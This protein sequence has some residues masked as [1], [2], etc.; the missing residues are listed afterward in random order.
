MLL[1]PDFSS[2]QGHICCANIRRCLSP[3]VWVSTHTT[4]GVCSGLARAYAR[5]ISPLADCPSTGTCWIPGS[6]RS[7]SISAVVDF[8]LA[9]RTGDDM[10][11]CCQSQPHPQRLDGRLKDPCFPP[12]LRRLER[13]LPG[14]GHEASCTTAPPFARARAIHASLRAGGTLVE[15]HLP[16]L[17]SGKQPQSSIHSRFHRRERLVFPSLFS[18]K[19]RTG[20]RD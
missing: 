16:S 3:V 19:F 6:W 8:Q 4:P 15:A 7:A 13:P 14:A 1:L 2:L 9:P 17:Q 10:T 12:V 5:T 18:P 20:P 11:P